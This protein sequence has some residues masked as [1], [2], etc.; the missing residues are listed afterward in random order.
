MLEAIREGKTKRLFSK[1][2]KKGRIANFM[3]AIRPFFWI[4]CLT[5]VG[6]ILSEANVNFELRLQILSA[7]TSSRSIKAR[8]V[9]HDQPY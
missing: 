7:H 1:P 9:L 6:F 4:D 5:N 2:Q 3:F 8:V